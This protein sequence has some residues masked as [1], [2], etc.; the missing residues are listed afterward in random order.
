MKLVHFALVA[1]GIPLADSVFRTMR[2]S[3]AAA[4][5]GSSARPEVR[6]QILATK[7]RQERNFW[8]AAM[9]FTLWCLLSVLFA[10]V[11]RMV[12]LEE[13]VEDLEDEVCDLKGLPRPTR[14]H[15]RVRDLAAAKAREARGAAERA[16]R[17]AGARLREAGGAAERRAREVGDIASAKAKE[18]QGE[19]LRKRDREGEERREAGP[20]GWRALSQ[21]NGPLPS[22]VSQSPSHPAPSKRCCAPTPPNTAAA[23]AT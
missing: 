20:L 4:R 19:S 9:A 13:D 10:Q 23:A 5:A 6:L 21:Q 7:W 14:V 1:S 16:S 2:A 18:V 12:K 17:A 11:T 22:F 3:E 15:P 8:I